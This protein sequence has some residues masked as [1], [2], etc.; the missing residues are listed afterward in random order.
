MGA[1]GCPRPAGSRLS[2]AV[3]LSLMLSTQCSCIQVGFDTLFLHWRRPVGL[4]PFIW[5]QSSD[6]TPLAISTTT[7]LTIE[8]YL[9]GKGQCDRVMVGN[10][11]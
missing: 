6:L 11:V 4:K 2:P 5:G 7:T 9:H 1:S 10:E 8:Y 3:G